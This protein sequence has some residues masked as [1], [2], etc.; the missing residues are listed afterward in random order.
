MIRE[1]LK[2]VFWVQKGLLMILIMCVAVA[3]F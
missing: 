2:R 1:E 3:I